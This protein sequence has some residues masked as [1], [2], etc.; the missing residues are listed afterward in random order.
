MQSSSVEQRSGDRTHS[1]QPQPRPRKALGLPLCAEFEPSSPRGWTGCSRDASVDITGHDRKPTGDPWNS[2]TRALPDPSGYADVHG[3]AIVLTDSTRSA[4]SAP[5]I[6]CRTVNCRPTV[7]NTD[8]HKN[9]RNALLSG[10]CISCQH[11]LRQARVRSRDLKGESH[12]T[13]D[14]DPP[15]RSDLG[16]GGRPRCP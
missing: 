7:A 4:G 13:H 11:G 9:R 14:S 15:S 10:P 12:D 8:V 5:D 2:G 6:T 3:C 1:P 16:G